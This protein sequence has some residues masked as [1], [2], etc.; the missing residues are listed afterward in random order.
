MENGRIAVPSLE[1]GGLDGQIAIRVSFFDEGEG[2]FRLMFNDADGQLQTHTF[3]KSNTLHWQE[4]KVIVGSYEFANGLEKNAD[5][6][7]DNA[8][9]DEDV[10]HMVEVTWHRTAY[11]P[12][13]LKTR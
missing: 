6:V 3:H 2:G 8:G 13:V 5:I 9:D 4:V 12:W 7:L 1:T 10:F 11:L